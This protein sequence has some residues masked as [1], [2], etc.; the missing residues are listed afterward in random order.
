MLRCLRLTVLE[1]YL[2]DKR[3]Q[4]SDGIGQK[5]KIDIDP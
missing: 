4:H 5:S 2:D 3:Q 1:Y